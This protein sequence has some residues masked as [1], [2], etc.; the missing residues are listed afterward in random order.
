MIYENNDLAEK[1]KII[2][3]TIILMI[4]LIIT[5]TYTFIIIQNYN[6]TIYI[7]EIQQ[8]QYVNIKNE[9]L[10]DYNIKGKISKIQ[11][12]Q[13]YAKLTGNTRSNYEDVIVYS[14]NKTSINDFSISFSK[15]IY[16]D[17]LGSCMPGIGLISS[18]DG[19][20]IQNLV[21]NNVTCIWVCSKLQEDGRTIRILGYSNSTGFVESNKKSY[22]TIGVRDYFIFSRTN[23]IC[24]L[25]IYNSSNYCNCS[26]K[27]VLY[28]NFTDDPFY[29]IFVCST[30]T[31]NLSFNY[32]SYQVGDIF[33][34]YL[35]HCEQ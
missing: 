25:M 7:L 35:C 21:V 2:L 27:D 28:L 20:D 5:L 3:I 18:I 19:H 34:D 24:K 10:L 9:D 32:A 15:I 4:I 13:T 33:I 12:N 23:N 22:Y 16:E 17:D 26:L 30:Y 11:I 29:Y 8:G 14:D 31:D 1:L 6:N